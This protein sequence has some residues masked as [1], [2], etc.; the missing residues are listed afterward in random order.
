M[1][2]IAPYS[3]E[4]RREAVRL[5]ALEWPVGAAARA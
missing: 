5:F 1:P 3:L 2:K 4:F